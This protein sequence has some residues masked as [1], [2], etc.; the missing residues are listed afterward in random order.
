MLFTPEGSGLLTLRAKITEPLE[1]PGTEPIVVVQIVPAGLPSGQLHTVG[2]LP[3]ALK[4]ALAGT[5]S[6]M[7]TPVAPV[8]LTLA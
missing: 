2:K 4:V 8:G 3:A 1:L 7:S 5:G 6:V